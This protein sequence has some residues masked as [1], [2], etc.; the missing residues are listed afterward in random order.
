[1]HTGFGTSIGFDLA[2]TDRVSLRVYDVGGRLVATL[3]D[4]RT[5]AAGNHRAEWDGRDASGTPARAGL[6]LYRLG[7]GPA[8]ETRRMVLTR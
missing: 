7:V 6:Y 5:L 2:R 3:I 1:M 4:G 8:S